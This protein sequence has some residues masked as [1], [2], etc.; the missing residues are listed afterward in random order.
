MIQES[1]VNAVR[2]KT[3]GSDAAGFLSRIGNRD[4]YAHHLSS[5]MFSVDGST[6]HVEGI[7][8]SM[9]G[10][11]FLKGF[12]DKNNYLIELECECK[13]TFYIKES[14]ITI[15][16]CEGRDERSTGGT[17][18][19]SW[20]PIHIDKHIQSEVF[21]DYLVKGTGIDSFKCSKCQQEIPICSSSLNANVD[22][23]TASVIDQA[24]II[25]LKVQ[26]ENL[27][28]IKT[29]GEEGKEWDTLAVE[30]ARNIG[31]RLNEIGGLDLCMLVYDELS[32][33]L[34]K[35]KDLRMLEI[36]WA[37]PIVPGWFP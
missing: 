25:Q 31:R 20:N 36:I 13:A 16:S 23:S 22:V 8:I 7:D 33:D 34:E 26:L 30:E 29:L 12:D 11:Y 19:Y 2:G 27:C 17:D 18:S 9:E 3:F 5:L 4:F 1:F 15:T 24:S 35:R 32:A 21:A 37:D 6:L 10:S 28:H 14:A